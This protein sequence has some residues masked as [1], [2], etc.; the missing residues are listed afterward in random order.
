MTAPYPRNTLALKSF[1]GCAS[2]GAFLPNG[3]QEKGTQNAHRKVGIFVASLV[4][5]NLGCG[6]FRTRQAGC[7]KLKHTLN[8]QLFVDDALPPH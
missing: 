3:P 6:T 5:R 1:G 2:V 8:E 7:D 4:C